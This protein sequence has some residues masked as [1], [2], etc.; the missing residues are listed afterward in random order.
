MRV[1][2]AGVLHHALHIRIAPAGVNPQLHVVEPLHLAVEGV[3]HELHFVVVFAVGVRHEVEGGFLDLDAAAAGVAQ[4][5]QL[6]V[7]RLRHVPDDLALVLVVRR[8]NIQ[9][10]RHH[11]RAAGAELDRLARLRLRDAP[12]LGIVERAVLDLAGDVRPA[13]AG[14]DFVQQRAGRIVEPRRGGLFRLQIVALEAGPALQRIVVPGAARHVFI[15]VQ[16]RRA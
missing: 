3:H 9:E 16:G 11:L 6:F 12:Q 10:Q 2:V 15:D 13:P 1:G 5:Q 4:R 14:I 7:H 8:V